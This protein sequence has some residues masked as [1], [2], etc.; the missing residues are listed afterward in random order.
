M[1]Y[2]SFLIFFLPFIPTLP[3]PAPHTPALSSA[4]LH[5]HGLYISSL[6]SLFP[7]PFLTSPSFMTSSYASYSLYLP[8][9]TLPLS[10]STENLPCDLH[11]S[12]SVSVLLHMVKFCLLTVKGLLYIYERFFLVFVLSAFDIR[13]ITSLI[14]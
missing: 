14:K 2:Y 1:Y 12:G 3:C 5:D 8:F 10:L 4:L 13:I 6:A 7:M 11:F 9:P